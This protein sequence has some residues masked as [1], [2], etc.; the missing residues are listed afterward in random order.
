[1]I[2]LRDVHGAALS[3]A[4]RPESTHGRRLSSTEASRLC[5]QAA[6]GLRLTFAGERSH[7]LPKGWN[8]VHVG[9]NKMSRIDG[10]RRNAAIEAPERERS[11]RPR[12]QCHL[13][14][15]VR[16]NTL[17]TE[18]PMNSSATTLHPRVVIIGA[19]FGGLSAAKQLPGALAAQASWPK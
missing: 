6:P 15:G 19:G 8:K 4:G 12:G 10:D 18:G 2:G 3:R 1:M 13:Q 14:E 16:I 11:G 7:P 5:R 9:V 17:V